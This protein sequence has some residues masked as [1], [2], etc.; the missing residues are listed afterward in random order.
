MD[1]QSQEPFENPL[2]FGYLDN[3]KYCKAATTKVPI[4]PFWQDKKF[5]TCLYHC[6]AKNILKNSL[7]LKQ[8]VCLYSIKSA[9]TSTF[10][11][12]MAKI[13]CF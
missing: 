9:R 3:P 12:L 5:K 4:K 10:S 11:I 8:K 7:L 6:L 1:L 2:Y 13:T